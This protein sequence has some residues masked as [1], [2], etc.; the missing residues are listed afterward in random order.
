[1]NFDCCNNIQWVQSSSFCVSYRSLVILF[2]HERVQRKVN[3]TFGN[4]TK[5]HSV[6][7]QTAL[8]PNT[9]YFI[10]SIQ[11]CLECNRFL[12]APLIQLLLFAVLCIKITLKIIVNWKNLKKSLFTRYFNRHFKIKFYLLNWSKLSSDD[13]KF[14]YARSSRM[15]SQ[16]PQNYPTLWGTS[17]KSFSFSFVCLGQRIPWLK[18]SYRPFKFNVELHKVEL[19]F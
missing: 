15:Y 14:R 6:P 4:Q 17:L 11:R 18:R 19:L 9:F 13:S 5:L 2:E 1:M 16:M 10:Y 7:K 3:N 12:R 8:I